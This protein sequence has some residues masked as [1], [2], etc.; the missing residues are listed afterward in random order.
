MVFGRKIEQT[1]MGESWGGGVNIAI[2]RRML[3]AGPRK[4]LMSEQNLKAARE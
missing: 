2:L 1:E 3:K 4:K